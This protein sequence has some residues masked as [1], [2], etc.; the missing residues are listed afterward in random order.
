MGQVS[1]R[2]AETLRSLLDGAFSPRLCASAGESF[3][4]C[5]VEFLFHRGAGGC[6][7]R[8]R[9]GS[10]SFSVMSRFSR[11]DA[12]AQRGLL[13]VSFSPRLCVSAGA[14]SSQGWTFPGPPSTRAVTIRGSVLLSGYQPT[15]WLMGGPTCGAWWL[16]VGKR[17]PGR[18]DARD[19]SRSLGFSPGTN[20]SSALKSPVFLMDGAEQ[21]CSGYILSE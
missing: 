20:F 5:V 12:E 1:R 21:E 6:D 13:F 16:C 19:K 18:N 3:R 8:R 15:E 17:R 9:S 10:I 14:F 2:D 4:Y 7:R 11:R